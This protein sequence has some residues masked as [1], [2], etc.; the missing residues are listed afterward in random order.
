MDLIKCM[1]V[2][3]SNNFW[4]DCIPPEDVIEENPRIRSRY[5]RPHVNCD[6]KV[7]HRILKR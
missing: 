7:L 4:E 5:Y 6:M 1:L 3:T 2:R